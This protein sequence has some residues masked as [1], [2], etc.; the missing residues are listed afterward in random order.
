MSLMNI[1]QNEDSKSRYIIISPVRDE[2]RYLDT[3]I[4]CV[5]NQTIQ[6]VQYILVDDG[7][8]DDTLSIIQ[9]WSAEYPWIIAVHRPNAASGTS[10]EKHQR[11]RG[12]RARAAKEILAF[13]EGFH[14]HALPGW[15]FLVKLDGD[16]GLEPDYFERCFQEFERDGRLGI[17]GGEICHLQHGIPVVER[18]PVFHVRGATKIYRNACWNDIGGVS[19]GAAWDSLDELK[20]NMLGWKTHTF[21]GLHV[22]HYRYT[23]AANGAWQEAVKKGEWNY[24]SGYHP[25]FMAC[26]VIKNAMERPWLQGAAG[27]CYGFL[28][29][30]FLRTPQVNDKKLIRYIRGQQLRRLCSLPTIWR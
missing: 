30:F 19:S 16:V 27:L 8:T 18:N 13:Y 22:L 24:I 2:G 21:P 25:L 9:R 11:N 23:G 17:G 1:S 7:S 28:R 20:A 4:R 29:A 10:Q 12:R 15:Q 6:P 5:V 14:R 26:K 3:T